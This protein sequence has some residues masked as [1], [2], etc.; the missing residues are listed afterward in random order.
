MYFSTIHGN[1]HH[2]AHETPYLLIA[3]FRESGQYVLNDRKVTASDH[4]FYMLNPGDQLEIDLRKKHALHTFLVAFD[5]VFVKDAFQVATRSADA[6]LDVAPEEASAAP[7]LPMVPFL[8]N[9]N[10][11][12]SLYSLLQSS[13]DDEIL[14]EILLAFFPLLRDTRN[15]LE[16]LKAAKHSTREE[17]Y[18][19]IIVAEEFMREHLSETVSLDQMAAAAC[20]NRFH[21][22]KLFKEMRHTT[23]HQYLTKLRLDQAYQQLKT[24]STSVSEVCYAVGFQ[25]PASFSHLFKRAYGC[26]PSALLK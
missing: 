24:G 6:L 2:P 17:I 5:E 11:S 25:S 9:D 23:P 26:A 13:Q 20:L 4:H 3:N 1:Y 22:L 10:I 19:R 14:A 21:F 16:N 12:H 7:S 18:R 8:M 15:Q